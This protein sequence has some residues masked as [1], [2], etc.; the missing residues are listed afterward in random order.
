MWKV[1]LVGVAVLVAASGCG[2]R[3]SAP[4][5]SASGAPAKSA[6]GG[7]AAKQQSDGRVLFQPES[8]TLSLAL[9]EFGPCELEHDRETKVS[10]VY[11]EKAG[12]QGQE[13]ILFN[14]YLPGVWN[15]EPFNAESVAMQLRD[16]SGPTSV[17]EG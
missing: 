1:G 12:S 3:E 17:V 4:A 7:T 10:I 8:K 11:C 6:D 15:T 14:F 5:Q 9:G 13:G 2:P 16:D